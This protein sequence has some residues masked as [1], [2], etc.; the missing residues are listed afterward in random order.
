MVNRAPK[1]PCCGSLVGNASQADI[2]G[3]LH[4]STFTTWLQV[5]GKDCFWPRL[6]PTSASLITEPWFNGRWQWSRLKDVY[7]PPLQLRQKKSLKSRNS[8]AVRWLG[9]W[10]FTAKDASSI[11]GPG[12][13]I[14]QALWCSKTNKKLSSHWMGLP[15]KFL[16]GNRQLADTLYVLYPSM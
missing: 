12:T 2:S 9:L 15:E 10:A 13:K 8:L 11:L 7:H 4:T 16:K 14:P 1:N 6:Y 5:C 3:I